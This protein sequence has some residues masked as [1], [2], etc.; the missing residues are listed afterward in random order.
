MLDFVF[1]RVSPLIIGRQRKLQE[2]A[3]D[4]FLAVVATVLTIITGSRS[5]LGTQLRGVCVQDAGMSS[6]CAHSQQ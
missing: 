2:A 1:S 3:Y 6:R 4:N 5:C